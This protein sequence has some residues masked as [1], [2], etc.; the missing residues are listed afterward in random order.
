MLNKSRWHFCDIKK[1]DIS[2]GVSLRRWV[3]GRYYLVTWN[4]LSV[5]KGIQFAVWNGIWKDGEWYDRKDDYKGNSMWKA[6][7]VAISEYKI[8]D[9]DYLEFITRCQKKGIGLC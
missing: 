8:S 2:D 6:L 3:K 9:K 5:E 1:S 4:L 7:R